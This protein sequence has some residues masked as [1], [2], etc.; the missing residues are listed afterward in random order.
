VRVAGLDPFSSGQAL[1]GVLSMVFQ[2]PSLLP[3]RTA[4]ENVAVGLEIIGTPRSERLAAAQCWL[5]RVHLA[6]AEDRFPAQLSGGMRQRVS[7][8]RAFVVEP[9]V[10]LDPVAFEQLRR[11][12]HERM[13]A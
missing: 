12:I 3:W 7:I 11:E 5:E 6:G 8:A 10:V 1:R 2:Q 9:S 4:R 13:T